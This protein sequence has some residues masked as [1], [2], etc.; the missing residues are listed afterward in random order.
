M[1]IVTSSSF[2][3]RPTRGNTPRVSFVIF[4][5]RQDIKRWFSRACFPFCTVKTRKHKFF[6]YVGS[7]KRKVAKVLKE[8]IN[9]SIFIVMLVSSHKGEN[10]KDGNGIFIISVP[11]KI[12]KDEKSIIITL[13]YVLKSFLQVA[14]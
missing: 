8:E 5:L 2:Y 10:K 12:K 14:F 11:E 9:I 7:T 13:I 6:Y 1:T 4:K 3:I